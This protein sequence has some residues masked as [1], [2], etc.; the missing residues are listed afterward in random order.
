MSTIAA[1]RRRRN[2]FRRIATAAAAA[3][4]TAAGRSAKR[5]VTSRLRF[6]GRKKKIPIRKFGKPRTTTRRKKNVATDLTSLRRLYNQ[7]SIKMCY[8][9]STKLV[10]DIPSVA[11]TN[12]TI[13]DHINHFTSYVCT[14]NGIAGPTAATYPVT[15]F[16]N[17]AICHYSQ[18]DYFKNLGKGFFE[19]TTEGG[20]AL[21]K[22][23]PD[24]EMNN[25]LY[26]MR[27]QWRKWK[28][29]TLEFVI[30]F[31][32]QS[33]LGSVGKLPNLKGYYRLF[34]GKVIRRAMVE[35]V[36]GDSPN[37]VI[38]YRQWRNAE[39]PD[40]IHHYDT[41][42]LSPME[43][44]E[45]EIGKPNPYEASPPAGYS[46][47]AFPNDFN[48]ENTDVMS[49][50]NVRESKL[51][52]PFQT[53]KTL[54]I[55]HKDTG[56]YQPTSSNVVGGNP[57]IILVIQSLNGYKA[58][59]F[60]MSQVNQNPTTGNFTGEIINQVDPVIEPKII[61]DIEILS[62]YAFSSRS[63]FGNPLPPMIANNPINTHPLNITSAGVGSLEIDLEDPDSWSTEPN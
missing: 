52:K 24:I 5:S 49:W 4:L 20:K 35:V 42:S 17:D 36:T 38:T 7:N 1:R 13:K 19:T 25:H 53:S 11:L 15:P 29:D 61:A 46:I 22:A 14:N 26:R 44:I 8:A 59:K 12:V 9:Q 21:L 3:A 63:E 33:Q 43:Q 37:Q 27:T 58:S 28:R 57:I 55:T 40:L 54:R 18:I 41:I 34:T 6:S 47:G 45:Q 32:K 2:A 51:W 62:C 60:S 31:R 30:R 23:Y 56:G 16:V 50:D 10:N 48:E 39:D